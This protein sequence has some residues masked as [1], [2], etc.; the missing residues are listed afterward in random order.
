MAGDFTNIAIAALYAAFVLLL[1]APTSLLVLR[2]PA[3]LGFLFA[4]ALVSTFFLPWTGVPF[5]VYA[6]LAPDCS[7]LWYPS[8][9]I[10]VLLP[11]RTRDNHGPKA[12]WVAVLS[13]TAASLGFFAFDIGAPG[14][15]LSIETI[16]TLFRLEG[17]Q[18]ARFSV[19]KSLF[20]LAL[21]VSFCELPGIEERGIASF[22]YA[23]YLSLLF[24]PFC[25]AKFPSLS[26]GMT[27]PL[28]FAAHILSALVMQKIFFRLAIRF[29]SKL[30]VHATRYMTPAA[31]A[32]AGTYFLFTS[33]A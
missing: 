26:P 7:Y 32:A 4:A 15:I 16:A 11:W 29:M 27:I 20:F 9:L 13:I 14:Q 18:G 1:A 21:F 3:N 5:A 12:A 2:K 31:F 8:M 24:L 33:S 25:D 22:S 23:A 6:G 30:R 19:A 17:L 10:C 28:V